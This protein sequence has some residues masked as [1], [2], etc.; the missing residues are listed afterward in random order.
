MLDEKKWISASFPMMISVGNF[1]VSHRNKRKFLIWMQLILPPEEMEA[2]RVGISL[3]R[4]FM[5]HAMTTRYVVCSVFQMRRETVSQRYQFRGRV[6]DTDS[7]EKVAGN[8]KKIC[9]RSDCVIE[10]FSHNFWEKFALLLQTT[11][12]EREKLIESQ[13]RFRN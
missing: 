12:R 5:R 9:I 11:R 1:P 4:K 8:K 2:Y 6:H 13:R 10:S 7:W 3:R